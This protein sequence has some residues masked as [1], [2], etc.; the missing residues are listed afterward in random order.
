MRTHQKL[1][2]K[3]C[4]LQLIAIS[5]LLC[6]LAALESGKLPA[7]LILAALYTLCRPLQVVC[8]GF[9]PQISRSDAGWGSDSVDGRFFSS[10]WPAGKRY[11]VPFPS[12]LFCFSRLFLA[13]FGGFGIIRPTYARSRLCFGWEICIADCSQGSVMPILTI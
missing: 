7:G 9:I 11:T 4:L 2:V 5:L 8:F 13:N 3:A 10:Y 1:I 12:W 6:S